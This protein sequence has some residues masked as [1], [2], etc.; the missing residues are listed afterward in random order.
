MA[1]PTRRLVASKLRC[2]GVCMPSSASF[3]G[4]WSALEACMRDMPGE[5]EFMALSMGTISSLRTSPTMRRSARMRWD[6]GTSPYRVTSPL[7]SALGGRASRAT[8]L[9]C[10]SGNASRANS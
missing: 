6:M 3:E 5:P 1:P 7:P 8:T 2:S 9:S 10:C 4:T